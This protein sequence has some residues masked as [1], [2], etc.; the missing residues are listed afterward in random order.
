MSRSD[1]AD[2]YVD[3]GD[4]VAVVGVAWVSVRRGLGSPGRCPGR[5]GFD[6][7]VLGTRKCEASAGAELHGSRGGLASVLGFV[8]LGELLTCWKSVV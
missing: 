7:I 6:R 4:F 8:G 3:L 5:E 2:A 1:S